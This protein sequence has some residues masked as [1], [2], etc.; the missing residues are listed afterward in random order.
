MNLASRIYIYHVRQTIF[1][2]CD[3]QRT[4][5]ILF[6]FGSIHFVHNFTLYLLL[7]LL[8]LLFKPLEVIL[9]VDTN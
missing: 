8:V 6:H 1:N 9:S 3:I 7:C 2:N 5:K 4:T